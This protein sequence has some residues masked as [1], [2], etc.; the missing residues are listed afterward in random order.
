MK[1]LLDVY[2]VLDVLLDR[3]PWVSGAKELWKA[4]DDGRIDGCVA[5]ISL[6]TVFYIVRKI[7]GSQKAREAVR[8]CLDAFHICSVDGR[9]LEMAYALSGVDFEDNV[10]IAC[11]VIATADYIATRDQA[12]L[13]NPQVPVKNADQIITL[14]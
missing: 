1:V 11:A 3:Q 10:Q 2:V 5:S 9:V 4:C 14:L 12:G 8:V 13:A 6:P 7:S